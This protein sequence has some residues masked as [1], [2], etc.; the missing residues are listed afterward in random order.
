MK[1]FE[2]HNEV[3][4]SLA[5]KGKVSW[6]GHTSA[7]ELLNHEINQALSKKIDHYFPDKTGKKAIDL[8]CGTGTAALYLASL[9]FE[10]L[11]YNLKT[12][13]GNPDT[14]VGWLKRKP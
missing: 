4:E 11:E 8:G 9:G 1:Y 7:S 10:V 6:D 14:F 12:S 5:Q 13:K 2:M 3:Y